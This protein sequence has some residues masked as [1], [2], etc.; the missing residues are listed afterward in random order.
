MAADELLRFLV[1]SLEDLGIPYAIGGSVASIGYGE[2]R[3]TMDIDVV[4]RLGAD[5]LAALIARFPPDE[6][7]VDAEAAAAAVSSGTQ[8]NVIHP[9][10]GFKIDIFVEG[11]EIE[12]AQIDRR[13]RLPVLP[14]L[15]AT[16]SPPEELILKKLQYFQMGGSDKHLRDVAAML[17]ISPD[18]IDLTRVRRLAADKGLLELWDDVQARASQ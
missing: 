18:Q 2:P 10:S 12:T 7:Y 1:E 3:A 9:S 6:F 8:F 13:R 5:A 16:F 4:I 15:T 11:D 14:G 17:R